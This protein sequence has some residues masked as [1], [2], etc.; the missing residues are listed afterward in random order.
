MI[1]TSWRIGEVLVDDIVLGIEGGVRVE[2][3]KRAS[4]SVGR[5]THEDED[6]NKNRRSQDWRCASVISVTSDLIYSQ[7]RP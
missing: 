7:R 3:L 6:L 2:W 1:S 5:I 4:V